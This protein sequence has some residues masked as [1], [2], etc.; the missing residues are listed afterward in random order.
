MPTSNFPLWTSK[1]QTDHR[2]M[3]NEAGAMRIVPAFF[4]A[5][6]GYMAV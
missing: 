6:A 3:K 1:K 2:R 4:M 5:T